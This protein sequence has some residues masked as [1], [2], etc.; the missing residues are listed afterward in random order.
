MVL[1]DE[2]G[3]E[4]MRLDSETRRYRMEGSLQ[5]VLEKGYQQDAQLQRWRRDKALELFGLGSGQK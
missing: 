1:F 4:V 5:L 3:K 2:T